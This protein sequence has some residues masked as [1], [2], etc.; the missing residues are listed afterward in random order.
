VKDPTSYESQALENVLERRRGTVLLRVLGWLLLVDLLQGLEQAPLQRQ[1]R[2]LLHGLVQTQV[3]GLLR[4][5]E[6]RLLRYGRR[7]RLRVQM[8]RREQALLRFGERGLEQK[9][10]QLQVRLLFW[11]LMRRP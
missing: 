9:P 7:V 6:R 11:A 3:R 1:E 5:R 2:T 10:W 8:Q 4:Q